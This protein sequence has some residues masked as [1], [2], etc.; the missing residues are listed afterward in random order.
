M[1]LFIGIIMTFIQGG[2]VRR[3]KQGTHIRAAIKAILI[4]IPSL[5]VIGLA[6]SQLYLYIGLAMYC[7][8]SAVVVQC[9][10]T[11]ISTF[12]SDEEKGKIT[13][14]ARGITALARAFGPTFTSMSMFL[15]QF[16]I[17]FI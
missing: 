7:Y 2:Y 3:I 11:V 10:T 14:I 9:F 5:V 15:N 17:K 13:G 1:F 8:A 12:G 16:L 6:P 4:L